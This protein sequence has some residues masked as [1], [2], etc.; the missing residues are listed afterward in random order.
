[1]HR[2]NLSISE[3][4]EFSNRILTEKCTFS[5]FMRSGTADVISIE[6]QLKK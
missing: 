2:T 6:I 3:M 4:M 5:N 1:M